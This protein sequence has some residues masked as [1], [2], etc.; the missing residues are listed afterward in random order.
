MA[1]SFSS[2]AT[3]AS[4]VLLCDA[5]GEAVLL[6]LKSEKYFGLDTVGTQMWNALTESPTIEAA[7]DRLLGAYEVEPETLRKDVTELVE[8]LVE[9]GLLV[10]SDPAV[11]GV[12]GE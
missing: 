6:D 12:A 3:T 1:V 10:V 9:H 4:D 5:D 2:R 8:K 11:T 7:C